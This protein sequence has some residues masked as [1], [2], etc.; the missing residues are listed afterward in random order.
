MTRVYLSHRLHTT[1][2][3]IYEDKMTCTCTHLRSNKEKTT[4]RET[5][6]SVHCIPSMCVRVRTLESVRTEK[7]QSI[8]STQTWNITKK[9]AFKL[10]ASVNMKKG[11]NWVPTWNKKKAARKSFLS[12]PS[13]PEK[14]RR[15]KEAK[16][17][18]SERGKA[19]EGEGEG[20]EKIMIKQ[21]SPAKGTPRT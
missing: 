5:S 1:D 17:R 10:P 18:G 12:R 13:F 8:Y 20:D 9:I 16:Q 6:E 15:R 2:C 21:M 19:K 14:R 7:L 11:K 4:I 3:V